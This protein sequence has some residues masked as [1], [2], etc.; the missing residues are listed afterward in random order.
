MDESAKKEPI[1]IF[2]L[3]K[4][5]RLALEETQEPNITRLKRKDTPVQESISATG[6]VS[7]Y[8][9]KRPV[10]ARLSTR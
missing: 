7:F 2:M 6:A 10:K 3:Q 5:P 8:I 1:S 4:R 9:T